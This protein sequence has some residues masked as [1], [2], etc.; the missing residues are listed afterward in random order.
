MTTEILGQARYFK[1]E[2]T[3][4]FGTFCRCLHRTVTVD[5]DIQCI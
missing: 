3:A 1:P 5:S 2:P 4:T